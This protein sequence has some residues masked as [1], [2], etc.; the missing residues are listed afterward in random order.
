MESGCAVKGGAGSEGRERA[1]KRGVR[2]KGKGRQGESSLRLSRDEKAQRGREKAAKRGERKEGSDI[3]Q[4]G[5][6][7][8]EEQEI[9]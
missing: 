8:R 6:K 2:E 5:G 1:R 4:Q 3:R 9:R 7:G